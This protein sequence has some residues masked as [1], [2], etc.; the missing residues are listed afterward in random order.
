MSE[1]Q[2]FLDILPAL[3]DEVFRAI[4]VNKKDYYERLRYW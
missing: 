2:D 4:R 1:Q 3:N